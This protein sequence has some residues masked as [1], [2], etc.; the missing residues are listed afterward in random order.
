[1]P[2]R[3]AMNVSLALTTWNVGGAACGS[4]VPP[5]IH[6]LLRG[7]A[8]GKGII[9]IGLQEVARPSSGWKAALLH[10]LP[11]GWVVCYGSR[12]AGM[13]V[14]VL[15]HEN[16]RLVVTPLRTMR[17]GTGVGDRWPNKGAVAVVLKVVRTTVCFVVAHLAAQEGNVKSRK[18]DYVS[19][20]RRLQ[21]EDSTHGSASV[22]LFK[23]YDHVF[24]MGDLNYRL[25]PPKE[26][27]SSLEAR[28][29]WVER[30]VKAANWAGLAAVDELAVERERAHVFVNYQEGPLRFA[31]TFKIE[32]GSK[33]DG[34]YNGARIPS[35]CDRILWHSLPARRPLLCQ[36]AY[37][38]VAS[39]RS[40][41]HVPVRALFQLQVPGNL[42]PRPTVRHKNGQ[43]VV[44]EFIF[45]RFRRHK[46]PEKRHRSIVRKVGSNISNSSSG[47]VRKRTVGRGNDAGPSAGRDEE[48]DDTDSASSSTSSSSLSSSPLSSSDFEDLCIDSD[49]SSS[50]SDDEELPRGRTSVRRTS[51]GRPSSCGKV[52]GSAALL[53][54]KDEHPDAGEEGGFGSVSDEER[55]DSLRRRRREKWADASAL[56]PIPARQLRDDG[57]EAVLDREEPQLRQLQGQLRAAR[58]KQLASASKVAVETPPPRQRLTAHTRSSSGPGALQVC[59]SGSGGLTTDGADE[60]V[61][62]DSLTQSL[63]QM[64]LVANFAAE[65]GS[66]SRGRH[67]V[68]HHR[69]RTR[70]SR[71]G[72]IMDVHG[73]SVFLK[74]RRIYRA[75]LKKRKDGSR[76]CDG[77]ALPA[78]PLHPVNTVNDLLYEHCQIS[79]WRAKSRMGTSGVLPLGDLVQQAPAAGGIRTLS[80]EL[81]L[82]KYG[83]PIATLEASVRL[84]VSDSLMWVDGK[85]RVVRSA[86]GGKAKNLGSSLSPRKAED[87]AKA[88]SLSSKAARTA[89]K[90]RAA[91]TVVAHHLD[92][93]GSERGGS[94]SGRRG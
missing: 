17:A 29:A 27:G 48:S 74:P 63:S 25:D 57:A 60:P 13:R 94:P 82:T 77:D 68:K 80:F 19:V 8:A 38:S 9:V 59:Y 11:K 10:S 6:E 32:P 66:V 93:L 26:A 56:Y 79:F 22:P 45:V 81:P 24:L 67:R 39:M 50:S 62:R 85:G 65:D 31:P 72:W 12:Y 86:T 1:V 14:L 2:R 90:A 69:R 53:C 4:G 35:Y 91:K 40:S 84:V 7:L 55:S 3:L 30:Y 44:L 87:S 42:T 73:A 43:R 16:L 46:K 71:G 28:V 88:L 20:I 61:K 37:S 78:I 83:A 75:E 41:D 21:N 54:G 34:G 64:S 76:A 52:E 51:E 58:D 18:E 33:Q 89:Q 15:V 23:T 5:D 49:S 92:S 36:T 70:L 47:V